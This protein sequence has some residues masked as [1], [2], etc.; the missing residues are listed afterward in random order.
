MSRQSMESEEIENIDTPIGQ[1]LLKLLMGKT[2][3]GLEVIL[4]ESTLEEFIDYR[5]D[6]FFEAIGYAYQSKAFHEGP[7]GHTGAM[8]IARSEAFRDI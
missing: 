6:L 2:G 7:V 8:E 1:E 4:E 3:K 5:C